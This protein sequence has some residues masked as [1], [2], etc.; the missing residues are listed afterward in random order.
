MKEFIK[1]LQAAGLSPNTQKGYW[2][3]TSKFIEWLDKEPINTQKKDVLDYL[4]YLK[5]NKLQKNA[6]RRNTLI[7]LNHYFEYLKESKQVAVN[8]VNLIRLNDKNGKQ[9]CTIF[10]VEQ[11][12]SLVDDFYNVYVKNFNDKHIPKNQH[13]HS[14]LTRNRNYCMLTFL[15][16][17]GLHTNELQ[18]ITMDDIDINRAKVKIRGGKRTNERVLPLEAGQIGALINYKQTIRDEILKYYSTTN[19]N[20]FL[21]MPKVSKSTTQQTGLMETLKPLRKQVENINSSFISFQQLRS[22]VITHWIKTYGLRKAQYFAGH[23]YIHNTEKYV[24]NDLESLIEDVNSYNP[25]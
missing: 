8:P 7:S 6:T 23:R 22:S 19:D 4:K 20:L 18:K 16:H 5:K 13:R 3:N 15:A 14:Y 10:S 12:T 1:Y 25:F 17:Q 9:L 24:P 2:F 11:L 21:S